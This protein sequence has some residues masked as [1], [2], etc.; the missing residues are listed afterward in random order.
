M[1]A[2]YFLV[3]RNGA[4][5]KMCVLFNSQPTR[6]GGVKSS[7]DWKMIIINLISEPS[8]TAKMTKS[9]TENKF[10]GNKWVIQKF[11]QISSFIMQT[12]VIF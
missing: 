8:P 9:T 7:S 10:W 2:Q 1:R 6:D 5:I 4:E 11:V 12:T 3:D